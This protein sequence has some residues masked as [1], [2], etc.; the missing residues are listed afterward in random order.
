MRRG[1]CSDGKDIEL[2]FC[3]VSGK[4]STVETTL[5]KGLNK[6]DGFVE[7]EDKPYC[8]L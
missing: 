6:G 3:E 1:D 4:V 5:Y 2:S 7:W 8:D